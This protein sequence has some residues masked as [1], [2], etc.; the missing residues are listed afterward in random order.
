MRYLA[1]ALAVVLAAAPLCSAELVGVTATLD[2]VTPTVNT[3]TV[4]CD[5]N[6]GGFPAQDTTTSTG[7]GTSR[8]QLNCTFD[9]STH[10]VTSI[11]GIKFLFSDGAGNPAPLAFDDVDLTFDFDIFGTLHV[12]SENLSGST[13]TGEQADYFRDPAGN[14]TKNPDNIPF[15]PVNSGAFVLNTSTDPSSDFLLYLSGGKF[16]IQGTGGLEYIQAVWEQWPWPSV[17]IDTPMPGSGTVTVGAPSIV[18]GV[19]TYG[20]DVSIPISA[21]YPVPDP[22][23]GSTPAGYMTAT[24]TME[25]SGEFTRAIP[26][27]GDANGDGDVDDEDASILGKY[28]MQSGDG[29]GWDQGDFNNDHIVNDKDAAIMAA[30]WGSPDGGNSVP[31]P[32]TA[33]LLLGLALAGLAAWRRR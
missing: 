18:A 10:A 7:S 27:L 25:M 6:V 30:H 32:S 21:K 33:V 14:P 28:W 8:F 20:V 22:T 19:A 16:Y 15:V 13:S 11:D 4:L 9:G 23:G 26:I 31:E 2:P 29:I 12:F 1:L 24:G 5:L 17:N 3:F